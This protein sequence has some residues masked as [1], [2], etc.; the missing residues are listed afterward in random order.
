VSGSD[1]TV[2]VEA[3]R[4][5]PDVS[6]ARRYAD[7]LAGPG[8]TRGVIGP[9]EADRVWGR[10][11]LNSAV[12]HPLCPIRS[13]VVD[14]GSGAGLPGIPLALVRGD[15][16]LTLLEPMARRVTWLEEVVDLLDLTSRVAV[17]RGRAELTDV[18]G[19]VV[20]SRAVAPLE[21]LL[22][23]S[24]RLTRPGGRVVALRGEAAG[25]ELT[26]VED[27]LVGWGLSGAR[28][29]RFGEGLLADPTTA[30]VAD[31]DERGGASDDT[32]V[33]GAARRRRAAAGRR[34]LESG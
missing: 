29:A 33:P 22:P 8:V 30:V 16:R 7:L 17:V 23:W 24:A 5:F 13:H 31:R 9:R 14:L 28:V 3:L 2:P 25:S 1:D 27:R 11:I 4:I 20:V 12:V 10:H 32:T 19:D 26:D 34:D 18:R 15:L 6:P 21:R